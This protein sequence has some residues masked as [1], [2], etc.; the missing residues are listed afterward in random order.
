[1]KRYFKFTTFLLFIWIVFSILFGIHDLDISK[2]IVNQETGW[3]KFLEEYGM[4]PGVLVILSGIYVYYSYIKQKSDVI[5]WIKKIFFFLVTT[6]LILYL[7]DIILSNILVESFVSDHILIFIST[8]FII[9]TGIFLLI[10]TNEPAQNINKINFAKIVVG[11]AF[12]GY[13]VLVQGVKY[14]CGR[15]R[16]RELDS[17]F[18]QFTPWYLPQG[19][20]GFDSFPSGHAATGWML[21]PLI[22]LVAD[23]KNWLKILVLL[24]VCC[25]AI[26]LA[27]SRVFIGAHY[28][29]DVLFGSF[30]IIAA[31]LFFNERYR[32]DKQ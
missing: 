12:F 15:V 19:I 14:C 9:N 4:I 25:W 20:T 13:V 16:F 17:V 11:M 7:L 2:H 31:F 28:A 3:T 30:I 5:S 10:H 23:K 26:T 6:C 18:S 8:S 24:L 29:S 21:L 22:I 27:V 1:M 32:L